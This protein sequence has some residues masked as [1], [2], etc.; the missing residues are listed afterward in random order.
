[1]EVFHVKTQ[2]IWEKFIEHIEIY[3]I[4]IVWPS[5]ITDR[6]SQDPELSNV[7]SNIADLAG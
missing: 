4:G 3:I 7:F 5:I 2:S 6:Y 1:M